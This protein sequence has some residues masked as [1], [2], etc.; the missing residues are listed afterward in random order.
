[1]TETK[2]R[3]N[4]CA[5]LSSAVLINPPQAPPIHDPSLQAD[6]RRAMVQAW[7]QARPQAATPAAASSC[8]PGM[9]MTWLPTAAALKGRVPTAAEPAQ[10]LARCRAMGTPCCHQL[11]MAA[12]MWQMVLP[13]AHGAPISH[14]QTTL[15]TRLTKCSGRAC[16][17]LTALEVSACMVSSCTVQPQAKPSAWLGTSVCCQNKMQDQP[18]LALCLHAKQRVETLLLQVVATARGGARS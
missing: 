14:L 1:M 9:V 13:T 17:P 11:L 2:H 12:Q 4:S 5:A 7:A 16:P 8:L 18:A 6:S 10:A 15:R 3:N